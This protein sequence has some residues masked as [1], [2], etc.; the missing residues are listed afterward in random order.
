[1]SVKTAV[2]GFL[3]KRTLVYAQKDPDKNIDKILNFMKMITPNKTYRDQ[4]ESARKNLHNGAY[5]DLITSVF[6]NIDTKM[7]TTLG[8]NFFVNTL[9]IGVQKNNEA[10][11]KFG[12]PGLFTIL[13]SPTM[14][15]NL[16]CIGCYAGEYTK[17]DDL[18]LDVIDSIIAQGKELGTY[19]YTIL[20]GEPFIREDMFEIY[21]RH[22]D[23]AFQVFTN[24]TLIDEEMVKK[25]K[26]VGNVMP[27]LSIE[28]FEK[29]TDERRGKGVF[30]KLMNTMD[31][32][33]RNKIVFGYSTTYTKLNADAVTSE[34]FLDMLIEKGAFWGWYFLYMPVGREPA[35]ELMATPEQRK[36]LGEFVRWARENKPIWPM[37]FWNDAPFVTGCIAGGR[38]YIHINHKGEVE[39]CIF[40]H[41]SG[42]NVKDKPLI[43][44]LKSPLFTTIRKFQ[45]FNKNLL[46]PCEIIDQ[47]KVFRYIYRKTKP[48]I[49]DLDADL[50]VKDEKLMKN[51]DEYSKK[52]G[53]IYK[54]VWDKEKT[55]E[56]YKDYVKKVNE[57]KK[58]RLNEEA[59]EKRKRYEEILKRKEEKKIEEAKEEVKKI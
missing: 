5:W 33:K 12:V 15:C 7:L 54:D 59:L 53:E 13:I 48:E 21:K 45:P 18:P 42:G 19:L 29:E 23:C 14:R 20:G 3:V 32:L 8:Y 39:P 49:T 24:G 37:D 47:P 16:R 2:A 4:I 40:L 46:M 34:K 36:K 44:I 38:R 56:K 1:M 17:K 41:F 28:G 6:K 50:L 27:V 26:E 22:S 43:E 57:E 11:K 31:L 51:L 35:T 58:K 30:Q 9:L 52:V 10:E 25:I 55:F